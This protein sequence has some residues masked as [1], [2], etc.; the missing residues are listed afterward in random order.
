MP[1]YAFLQRKAD[2]HTDSLMTVANFKGKAHTIFLYIFPKVECEGTLPNVSYE[3]SVIMISK[4][5]RHND[6]HQRKTT[7][8]FYCNLQLGFLIG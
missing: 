1:S 5:E 6:N 2:Y 4:P 8:Y 3:A 7:D